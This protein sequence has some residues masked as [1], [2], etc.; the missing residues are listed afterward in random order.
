LNIEKNGNR[1]SLIFEIAK[2]L[3]LNYTTNKKVTQLLF[4]RLINWEKKKLDLQTP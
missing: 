3:E 1:G 2:I 4:D